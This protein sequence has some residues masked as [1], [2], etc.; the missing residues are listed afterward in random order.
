MH[1]VNKQTFDNA[2]DNKVDKSTSKTVFYG[3]DADG[4]QIVK[5]YSVAKSSHSAMIRDDAGRTQVGTPVEGT[6][7]AN[8]DYVD[9]QKTVVDSAISSTSTNPVQNKVI[10]AALD[11]E[12]TTR[13]NA[14]TTIQNN[15]TSEISNRQNADL[16]LQNNIDS[17]ATARANADNTE[18]TTRSNADTTLQNNIDNEALARTNAIDN[19]ALIRSNKDTDLQDQINNLSTIGRYLS[20]W[21]ASIGKPATEPATMPYN[22]KSGDYYII[23]GVGVTN[24]RPTGAQYTGVASTTVETEDIANNGFY[25]YDGTSW[26]Y[27]AHA[28]K[29]VTF[30]T[31]G[32]SPY[33]N[34]NLK[35][36]LDAK[37]NVTDLNTHTTNATVH[38]TSADKTN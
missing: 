16:T 36:A 14:D 3:T 4:K 32:G 33:E 9:A 35:T 25:Q 10:K 15:L 29:D 24:Y 34:A 5:S 8:K 30:S 7:A 21:N 17:E 2:V 28:A 11:D 6:H 27:L 23:N 18:A 37:A 31:I 12:A 19:E 20:T 38:V 26:I 22:Y 13:A 1:A